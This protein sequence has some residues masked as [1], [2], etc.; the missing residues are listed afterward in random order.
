MTE[1]KAD[2]VTESVFSLRLWLSLFL[3]KSEALT[4]TVNESCAIV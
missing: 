3:I 2:S 4:I 1:L